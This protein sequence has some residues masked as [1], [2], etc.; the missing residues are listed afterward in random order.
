LNGFGMKISVFTGWGST[1]CVPIL[2]EL[3][4]SDFDIVN[5]FSMG[6]YWKELEKHRKPYYLNYRDNVR[7]FIDSSAVRDLYTEIRSV[8]DQAIIDKVRQSGADFAFFVAF[9]EIVKKRTLEQFGC[10]IVNF[11]AGLL[12]ESQGADVSNYVIR[13]GLEETGVTIHYMSD[14]VDS[15]EI[16]VRRLLPELEGDEDYNLLQAKK[17]YLAASAID[18]LHLNLK[19]KNFAPIEVEDIPAKY[20]K[21]MKA[22]S[23][24][25]D[26][27]NGSEEILRTIRCFSNTMNIAYIPHKGIKIY[28]NNGRR[29][30][31]LFSCSDGHP[32]QVIDT[33]YNF[34]VV[35]SGDDD[36]LLQNIF[37]NDYDISMSSQLLQEILPTG[38]VIQPTSEISS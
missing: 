25:I 27:S 9:G 14:I 34:V 36:I 4:R 6:T 11:H 15:G 21:R 23:E 29:I 30:S 7:E 37:V 32:G 8:N 38:S 24:K 31:K 33:G 13:D 3:V 16:L 1:F 19:N 2:R 17:G 28:I 22:E 35:S 12:P 5:I 18:E 10:R 26:L 20:L